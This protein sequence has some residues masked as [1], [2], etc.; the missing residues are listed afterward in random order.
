[1]SSSEKSVVGNPPCVIPSE[2]SDRSRLLLSRGHRVGAAAIIVAGAIPL[3]I[4]LGL[5]LTLSP[6]PRSADDFWYVL[7]IAAAVLGVAVVVGGMVATGH[8]VEITP[9]EIVLE[10]TTFGWWR[11][12]ALPLG[13]SALARRA[14]VHSTVDGPHGTR[15]VKS[16]NVRVATGRGADVLLHPPRM[17]AEDA[18]FVVNTINNF[19]AV[20]RRDDQ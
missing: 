8:A 2:D 20:R 11:R 14:E 5:R 16:F 18:R 15:T 9:E 10:S 6:G 17:E 4:L 7:V 12:R 13:E 19:L 3:V 1:M